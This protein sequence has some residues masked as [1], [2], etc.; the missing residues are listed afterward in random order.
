MT[1]TPMPAGMPRLWKYGV[2]VNREAED[3][4]GHRQTGADDHV[5]GAAIHGEVRRHPIL[6]GLPGLLVPAQQ[7][8]RVVRSRSHGE[9]GQQVGGVRRER[10]DAD[11]SQKGD[12]TARRGDLDG[13]SHQREQRG[14]D[15]AVD[16]QQHHR[17]HP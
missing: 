16:D 10:N 15:R 3:R 9:Q 14:D 5:C 11:M 2:L 13:D 4:R 17:D 7:E 8:D 12:Y 6:P 1:S